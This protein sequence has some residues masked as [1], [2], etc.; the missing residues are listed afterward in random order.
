M[1]LTELVCK[2]QAEAHEGH[3]MYNVVVKDSKD[4]TYIPNG[5]SIR[6]DHEKE[7]IEISVENQ[8]K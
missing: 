1:T 5:I 4:N 7:I 8:G 2:L 3:A 6:H